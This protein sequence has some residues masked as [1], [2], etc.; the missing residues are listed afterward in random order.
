M[1]N[2]DNKGFK[3]IEDKNISDTK[4]EVNIEK[5][6]DNKKLPSWSIEP[7]LEIKRNTK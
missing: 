7:P 2:N 1:E 5:K 6:N 3:S 4:K